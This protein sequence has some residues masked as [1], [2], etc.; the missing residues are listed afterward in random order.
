[1]FE[2]DEDMELQI[3]TC[4]KKLPSRENCSFKWEFFPKVYLSK[5]GLSQHETTKQQQCSTHSVS[6]SDSGSSRSRLEFQ[7]YVSEECPKIISR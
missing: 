1:M 3:V 2:N 6:H 4:I 5:A 7:F